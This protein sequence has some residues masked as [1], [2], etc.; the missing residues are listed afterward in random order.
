MEF[1][2]VTEKYAT[3]DTYTVC[4]KF[5]LETR[6]NCAEVATDFCA[7]EVNFLERGTVF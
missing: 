2:S 5:P 7:E 4:A 1:S 3:L 6:A